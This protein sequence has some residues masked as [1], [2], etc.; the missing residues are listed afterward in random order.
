MIHGRLLLG[1]SLVAFATPA[2]ADHDGPTGIGGGAGMNVLSADTLDAGQGSVGLRLTYTDPEDRSDTELAA[3]AGQH[4][5]AHNTDYNLVTAVGA[6]YGITHHLTL[7]AELPFVRRDD[8]REGTH[9]HEDEVTINSVEKLGTVA[10]IGDATILAKYRFGDGRAKFALIA[11][12]KLPTGGTHEKS[13]DD[14]RLETEHQ[15]GTGSWD[16][17]LGAALGT[18]VGALNLG[19]SA[20]YQLS[21]K[22]AQHTRLGDR[23]QGGIALSR[24]FGPSEH[25]EEADEAHEHG[26]HHDHAEHRHSSWDAF[27]ELTGEWEGR[28]KVDGE[29]EEASGG[30]SVWLSP[31]ARY[32][33]AG[34]FSIAGSV[35]LPVWQHVRDSHPDNDYRLT[36]SIAHAI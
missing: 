14:E 23:M 6:G 22:A 20:V 9:A 21:G 36:L 12:L 33:S 26:E 16:P 28:Q 7:S 13:R 8:L 2:L 5:H 3:L 24:H 27:L 25:H 4:V 34:G 30:K 29:V 18:K 10:G 11:G 19:A 17:I 1:A 15:P 35:G 32:N 31:G